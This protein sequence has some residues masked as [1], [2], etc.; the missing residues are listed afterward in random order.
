[1]MNVVARQK[2]GVVLDIIRPVSAAE[3]HNVTE[4]LLLR[5][6]STMALAPEVGSVK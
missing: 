4:A 6:L 1:M 3:S 5:L 2:F